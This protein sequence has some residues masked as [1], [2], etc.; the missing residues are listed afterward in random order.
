MGR[1]GGEE[2]FAADLARKAGTIA[3]EI[4]TG[5]SSRVER[6]YFHPAGEAQTNS[7]G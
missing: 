4:F 7:P 5:V 3:W 6:I 2:I 1:Q